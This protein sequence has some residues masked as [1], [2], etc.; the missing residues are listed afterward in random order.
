MTKINK[1]DN[2]FQRVML[3]LIQNEPDK[4]RQRVL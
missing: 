4:A 1:D 3:H 2:V